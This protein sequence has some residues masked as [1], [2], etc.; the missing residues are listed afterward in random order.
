VCVRLPLAPV[1]VN[2]N[3]PRGVRAVLIARIDVPVGVTEGGL[4]E[5]DDPAGSPLADSK[6]AP[7]NPFSDAT[8]TV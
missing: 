8:V 6:T 4:N 3:V 7:A 5:P 2:V 1:T